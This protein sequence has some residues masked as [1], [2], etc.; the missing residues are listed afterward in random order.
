M[1]GQRGA[2]EIFRETS[3]AINMETKV[4]RIVYNQESEQNK[5]GRVIT[6][7]HRVKGVRER[8]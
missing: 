2:R 5:R 8:S 1:D 6:E 4:C 7:R 3:S